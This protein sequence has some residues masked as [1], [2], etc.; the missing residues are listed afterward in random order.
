MKYVQGVIK[1]IIFHSE[2]NSYTIIKVK[3][4]DSTEELNLFAYD[5]YDYLTVTGYF[6]LP[7][8]GEE[9]KFFGEFKEHNRYGYQYIVR[10][11]E[12]IS[13]TSIPGLIEYLSSD[14][15]KGVG[16]KTAV[17]IVAALGKDTIKKV[18]EDK[19]ILQTVPKLS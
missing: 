2:D 15:F 1:A 9:M 11:F 13:D 14:L 12:K 6:P 10:N 18:I 4:T 5:D 19:E 3:V 8:R 16:I 7:I 17:N